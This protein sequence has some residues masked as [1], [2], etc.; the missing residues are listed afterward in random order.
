[1]QYKVEREDEGF[2][3]GATLLFIR[4]TSQDGVRKP[5]GA[6]VK[7]GPAVPKGWM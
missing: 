1:M 7:C 6:E 4:A 2:M 3:N 5:I